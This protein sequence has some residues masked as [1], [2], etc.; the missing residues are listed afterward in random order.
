VGPSLCGSGL[1][2]GGCFKIQSTAPGSQ[3]KHRPPSSRKC[4]IT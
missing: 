4:H 1:S 3:G 2:P